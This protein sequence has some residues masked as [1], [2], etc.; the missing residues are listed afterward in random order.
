MEKLTRFMKNVFPTLEEH[1]FITVVRIG[2]NKTEEIRCKNID[3]AVSFCNR[4][5]KYFYN[6]YFS[7]ATTD[8]CGRRTENMRTRSCLCWDFDK[9]TLGE[10]FNVK[11]ILHLFKSI[12]LYYHCIVDTAHGYH[13]YVFIEPTTDLEA[14]EAVQKAVA[15]RLGADTHATLKTQL[16]RVPGTVNI[17][18]GNKFPVKIVYL[19]DNAH[20]KRLPISHYQYNYV[21]ERYKTGNTNIKWAMR[22]DRLPYCVRNILE[23]GS[24]VGERN[25]DLQTI[26]V[27]LKRL[28]KSEA[29]VRAVVSEWLENTEKMEDLDYQLHYMYENLYNGCLNC[30][31][32]PYRSECYVRDTVVKP[33]D[34]PVLKIPDRDLVKIKNSRIKKKG[35]KY[36]NG[37]MLI[38]YSVLLRHN[39]GLFK[40]E[41]T[42]ELTYKNPEKGIEA[43]CCM[44]DKTIRNTLKE[45]EENGFIEVKTVDRKKV[46]K[47]KANRVSAENKFT[48][49]YASAYEVVKGC[50]TAEEFQLYCYMK[51]LCKI[52]PKKRGEDPFSLQVNQD[53]LA[54]DLGVDRSV[55]TKMIQNLIDEKLI[56]LYSRNKSKNNNFMYNTYLLNY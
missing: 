52:T 28:G 55:V 23:R 38:I 53:K 3:E 5:D 24:E 26:V 4:K 33:L 17:K 47:L 27:A 18:H 54:D 6:S 45:L 14:V 48:V 41:L 51:Y 34:Y 56:Q 37:N 46:Y 36:M 12:R 40:D 42:E 7:L 11:D 31:E 43:K 22:D 25:A 35:K 44:S 21:T 30:K 10:D 19:S 1:E 32:C 20:I 15:V 2:D 29:E 13:V 16:M 49:S 8:G 50:I 9:K 39:K